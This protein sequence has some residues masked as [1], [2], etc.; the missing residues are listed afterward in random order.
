MSRRIAGLT[1]RQRD[2]LIGARDGL[3]N[4][5]I[6]ERLGINWRTV[7]ATLLNAFDTLGVNDRTS[8]VVTA[9]KQGLIP[10]E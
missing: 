8:A 10:L 3:R 6:A 5:E 2:V 1:P 7:S 9:I 4:K